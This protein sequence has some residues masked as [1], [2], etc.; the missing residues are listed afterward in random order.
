[1][2]DFAENDGSF[3]EKLQDDKPILALCDVKDCMYKFK[4]TIEEILN[5]D[6]HG[7]RLAK[8]VTKK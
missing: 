4:A 7:T 2:G 8:S 6:E 5:K 3:L 1:M